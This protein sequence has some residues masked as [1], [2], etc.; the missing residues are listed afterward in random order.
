MIVNK[1]YRKEVKHK[2]YHFLGCA[3]VNSWVKQTYGGPSEYSCNCGALSEKEKKEIKREMYKDYKEICSKVDEST[4]CGNCDSLLDKERV[5]KYTKQ[6]GFLTKWLRKE[7]INLLH[8][9]LVDDKPVCQRCDYLQT[10]YE[11]DEEFYLDYM[12]HC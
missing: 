1:I 3:G 4:K 2:G 8:T 11:M 12:S 5:L 6:K 7:P 10:Q 9:R